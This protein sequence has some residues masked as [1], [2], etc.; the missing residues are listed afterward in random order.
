MFSIKYI[1]Y[2]VSSATVQVI[3]ALKSVTT[4]DRHNA[5]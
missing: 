4:R 1:C 2:P 5:D 3:Q